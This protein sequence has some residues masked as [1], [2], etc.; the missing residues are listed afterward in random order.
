MFQLRAQPP[1]DGAVFEARV[2][3]GLAHAAKAAV[4]GHVS[5]IV[6]HRGGVDMLLLRQLRL[7]DFP[8]AGRCSD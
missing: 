2:P 3:V 5:C 8:T 7:R 1:P 6:R 4:G